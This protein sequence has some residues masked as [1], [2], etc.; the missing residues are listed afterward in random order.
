MLK[1]AIPNKGQ[2]A[3]PTQ[4][5]LREA[6]FLRSHHPR[7][8]VVSD[9]DND[10][11]F[12]F[13]RPRDVATYVGAGNLDFGITG[14]DLLIDSKSN[15]EVMIDLGFGKSKFRIATDSNSRIDQITDLNNK[16]IATSYPN[17]LMN[18]LKQKSLEAEIVNLDGAVEN[19]IRLGLADAIADVVDTGTTMKQAGLNFIGEP[20]MESQAVLIKS[21]K[22]SNSNEVDIFLRRINSVLVARE[23]VMMDY[24]VEKSNLDKATLITPGFESPTISPLQESNW[25]AVRSMVKK[26]DVHKVMDD[27][28]KIGAKAIIVTEIMACRL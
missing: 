6:G 12:F 5:L 24:D 17:L 21:K 3:D 14:N 1:I 19:A 26:S 25:V 13:L 7:D 16:R 8:L 11:E 28:Y 2:L 22:V 15:A 18:W 9:P 23:Y 4:K 27:L 20:L 10:I